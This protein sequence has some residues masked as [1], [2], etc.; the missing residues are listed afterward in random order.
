MYSFEPPLRT[1]LKEYPQLF[2]LIAKLYISCDRISLNIIE[3][4]GITPQV[5]WMILSI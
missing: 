4:K 5:H 1:D 3:E 2:F